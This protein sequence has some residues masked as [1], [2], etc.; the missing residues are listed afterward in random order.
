LVWDQEVTGSSPVAPIPVT[1]I[2]FFLNKSVAI[3]RRHAKN[4]ERNTAQL[5]NR[6]WET[7]VTKEEDIFNLVKEGNC[8]RWQR[9]EKIELKEFGS[10][11]NLKVIEIGS[12]AG[13]YAALMAKRGARATILDYSKGARQGARIF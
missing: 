10:F 7:P 11:N 5:W 9:I 2:V 8:I 3:S 13:T 12:G 6:A 4:M 1:G